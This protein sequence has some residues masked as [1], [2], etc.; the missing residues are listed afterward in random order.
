MRVPPRQA[1]V[2]LGSSRSDGNT[3][4]AVDAVLGARSVRIVDLSRLRISPYDYEHRNADDDF[5]RTV[6]SIASA[7]LWILATPVYWFSMSARLKTFVD[8]L[9]DLFEV[10]E[11]LGRRLQGKSLAL[12]ATGA[13]A[14]LPAGFQAPFRH[15]GEYAG[16][17]Y[18]G[19][20]YARFHDG[21]R[22]YPRLAAR[23]KKAGDAWLE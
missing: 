3:R 23:A 16:M 9:C 13:G 2:I 6:E 20:F 10:R 4:R 7:S 19:A 1:V 21:G 5:L 12:V 22:P 15:L 18:A 11:D 17:R 14:G 8:R